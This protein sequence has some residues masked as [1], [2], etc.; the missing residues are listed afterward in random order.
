[1]AMPVRKDLR[2]PIRFA[3]FSM[4]VVA[5]A[6]SILG[7]MMN[8][9]ATWR[10]LEFNGDD[11]ASFAKRQ[12]VFVVLGIAVMAVTATID[13]RIYKD[14]ANQGYLVVLFLLVAVLFVGREING[15]R[16]WFEVP[17]L[18]IQLQPSEFAK[19]TVILAI[20]AFVAN[21]Q[22]NLKFDALVNALLLG[23]VP[24]A[25]IF[26]QP[27]IGTML[28]F[29]AIMMGML[30]VAGAQMRHIMLTTLLGLLT[31]FAVFNADKVGL[32]LVSANQEGRLTAFLDPEA[33]PGGASYNLR[34]SQIAIG[35]GGF[36]G[37]GY[38]QGTQTNLNLVPEQETDFIF[39]AVGEEFGFVGGV[40]LIL[41]YGYLL[42][43]MWR[44]AQG[45]RDL[46]G[47]FVAVGVMSMFLFQVFQNIGMTMGIMPITGIPLPFMS[48]GGSSTITAFAALGLA[49]NVSARRFM[50]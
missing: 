25:L 30:L 45:A 4:V 48:H 3:D 34:Q 5:I 43:R 33:D 26:R 13:Y 1:M 22:G 19:V 27:D 29:V 23:V 2:S 24:M 38:L 21:H 20:A 39:T 28:V 32:E 7:V 42:L 50:A 37:R 40:A 41:G 8:Y 36:T 18:P 31:I 6:I 16:S 49:V 9:A 14:F 17:G 44:A 10:L 15:A 35:A 46:F 47:T 11:P 12:A